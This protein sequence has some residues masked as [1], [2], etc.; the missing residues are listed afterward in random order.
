MSRTPALS[1]FPAVF[2]GLRMG[3]WFAWEALTLTLMLG[4]HC[5][6]NKFCFPV[7]LTLL[8]QLRIR[9]TCRSQIPG[10]AVVLGKSLFLLS[11]V[12]TTEQDGA[13]LND[14]SGASRLHVLGASVKVKGESPDQFTG[15]QWMCALC[16]P[17]NATLSLLGLLCDYSPSEWP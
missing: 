17:V 5:G 6:K 11:P 12:S 10:L 13:G 2:H 7:F 16:S 3:L 8:I 4:Q 1:S 9:N 14:F 15:C